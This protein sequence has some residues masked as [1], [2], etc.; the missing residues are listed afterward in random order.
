MVLILEC[1]YIYFIYYYLLYISD[2]PE[3]L[4]TDKNNDGPECKT[5][6][7]GQEDD[8][9]FLHEMIGQVSPYLI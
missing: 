2:G 1:I 7:M 4:C 5:K 3:C 6:K 8:R 9:G